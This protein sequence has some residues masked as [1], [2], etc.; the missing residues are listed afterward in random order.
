MRRGAGAIG[1]AI[2]STGARAVGVERGA[3][4]W[5]IAAARNEGE[6]TQAIV[7]EL[8]AH[9][10]SWSRWRR[11]RAYV[12]VGASAAQLKKLA[13][14][15]PVKDPAALAQLVRESA[16]RF[17]LKNGV[18][19]VVSGVRAADEGSAWAA[20]V[21]AP[22]VA[23]VLAA[24]AARR[25]RVAAIVPAPL[26]VARAVS[27]GAIALDD[28]TASVVVT[29]ASRMPV[30]IR[31]AVTGD[32][33]PGVGDGTAG[34]VPA[35]AA[36]GDEAPD[37][38]AAYGATQLEAREPLAITATGGATAAAHRTGGI[39]A[40]A[41]VL[42]AVAWAVIAP[43][44]A[45]T[46]ALRAD[47]RALAATRAPVEAALARERALEA[48]TTLLTELDAFARDRRSAT[49]LLADLAHALPTASAMVDLQVDSAGGTLVAL[50]PRAADV[51]K[52]VDALPT[53]SGVAIVGPVTR[54]TAGTREV[55]RVTLRFRFASEY[56]AS[57]RGRPRAAGGARR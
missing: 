25:V 50:A 36:L 22:V 15:P 47:T 52:A 13:G 27:D 32:A 10:P 40:A 29:V 48:T 23:E 54:E 21:E 19:L 44:L 55:E 20:A 24:C 9:C 11:P 6:S 53:L 46:L 3:V 12:A 38:A 30:A 7:T 56:F 1:I 57:D 45:A 42:V 16:G 18:P 4:R 37:Y 5:A 31:R 33:A 34:I 51:V 35:L 41:A 26:A 2:T 39:F 43:V 8:L 49:L 17:F 28:G 14:L